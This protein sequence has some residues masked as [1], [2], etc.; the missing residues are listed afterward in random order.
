MTFP[1]TS[2]GFQKKIAEMQKKGI[3]TRSDA[4]KF[5]IL[6]LKAVE[7]EIEKVRKYKDEPV[8]AGL[9]AR[10][11]LIKTRWEKKMKFTV[12]HINDPIEHA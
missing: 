5:A 11:D 10:Y 4:Y 3:K 2:D 1:R 12:D 8:I 7:F 9:L 6:N